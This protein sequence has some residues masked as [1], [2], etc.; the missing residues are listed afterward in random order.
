MNYRFE[1]EGLRGLA[2]IS[3]LL[4]HLE[5]KVKSITLFSNGFLGVDIFFDYGYFTID[6]AKFLGE[7]FYEDLLLLINN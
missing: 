7:I 2:V 3:I 5:F 1:I 6:G 4:Y